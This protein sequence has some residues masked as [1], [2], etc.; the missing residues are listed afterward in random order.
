MIKNVQ[1]EGN[2]FFAEA[3]DMITKEDVESV[4]PVVEKMIAEHKKVKCLMVVTEFKGYTI[5]GLLGDFGFYFKHKDAFDNM[6]IVGNKEL[7][8]KIAEFFGFFMPG[9]MK[10][11]DISEFE[12]AKEWIRKI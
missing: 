9:K 4:V 3:C 2:I 8:G 10:Y 12:Q 7:G 11:F 1:I 5:E 6:A